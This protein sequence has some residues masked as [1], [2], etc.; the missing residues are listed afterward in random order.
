MKTLQ[1]GWGRDNQ[2]VRNAVA[3]DFDVVERLGVGGSATVFHAVRRSDGRDVA[4]KIMHPTLMSDPQHVARFEREARATTLLEHPHIVRIHAAVQR[5]GLYCIEMPLFRCSLRD[6]LQSSQYPVP[7]AVAL[8]WL[9]QVC[10]AVAYAHDNDV[11]HRDLNPS[12][13]LLDE[14]GN[15]V[16]TD[17]GLAFGAADARLTDFGFVVGTATYMSPERR[18]GADAT[19]ASDLYSIGV[20]A[21]ELITGR[22]LPVPIIAAEDADAAF[23]RAP[24]KCPARIR[25]AVLK[26][27]SSSP[28][29][30]CRSARDAAE[31]L[32]ARQLHP[33]DVNLRWTRVFPVTRR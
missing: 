14:D 29:D 28:E 12:N 7:L 3:S 11:L 9:A 1:F 31:Q 4:L 33:G 19:I 2:V 6:R 20:V 8:H 5:G 23:N 22:F 32:N 30:R 15:A 27:V 21:L 10:S 25:E 17:F 26:L 13:I 24:I 16:L 18:A